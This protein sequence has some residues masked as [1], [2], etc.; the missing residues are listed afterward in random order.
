M[1]WDEGASNEEKLHKIINQK[2]LAMYPDGQEAWSEFRRTGYP[3]LFPVVN[4][5]SSGDW[6]I[7]QGEFIKRLPFA[8]CDQIVRLLAFGGILERTSKII[9]VHK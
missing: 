9:L 7:P 2:W 1:K 6:T 8:K 3:K 5:M 4:N